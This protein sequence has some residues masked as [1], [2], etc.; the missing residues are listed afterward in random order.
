[1]ENPLVPIALDEPFEFACSPQ[2][3]CFNAC[4]RDLNQFL[5]PYDILRLKTGLGMSSGRFL[6]TYTSL[7]TGPETGLPVI[8]LTPAQTDERECP[9]LTAA[10]C[11]VYA[12]RPASCRMYPIARA[13]TRSRET[14]RLTEHYALLKEP[15]CLGFR[16][17]KPRTVRQWLADQGLEPYNRYND[18]MMEIISLKNSRRPGPLDMASRHCLYLALYDLDA[19]RTSI[20]DGGLLENHPV[21]EA[22][23]AAAA[24]DDL[25]LLKLGLNWLKQTLFDQ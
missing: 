19:F 24:T 11:R 10:G 1:M 21:A 15:H 4:C 17:G 18:L 9:F 13:V 7:H 2:V 16:Q 25:A 23:M 8:T 22:E 6:E 12:D 3:P 14:G 5:T 20:R